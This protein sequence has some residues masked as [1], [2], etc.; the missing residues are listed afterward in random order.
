MG[1]SSITIQEQGFIVLQRLAADA[2]QA[3]ER[4]QQILLHSSHGKWNTPEAAIED[5][6][7]Q[8]LAAME[9]HPTAP[10]IAEGGV[11]ALN[12]MVPLLTTK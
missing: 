12:D 11:H 6:F 9:A 4:Q 5:M 10:S 1:L 7:L 2:L 3:P 8:V